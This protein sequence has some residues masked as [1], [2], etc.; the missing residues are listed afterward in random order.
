MLVCTSLLALPPLLRLS[1]AAAAL[2][3]AS[4]MCADSQT[5]C[6]ADYSVSGE[7]CCTMPNAVC[8]G[9]GQTCCP[10]GTRCIVSDVYLTRCVETSTNRIVQMGLSVCK[11]GAQLP[12]DKHRK[13]VVVLGDSVSIGYF[14]SLVPLLADVAM[15]QHSPY[16][17]S[18]GGA[19]ETAYGLQ[20]WDFFIRDPQ[21]A[22][23]QPDV[24]L[25]N[26]GLHNGAMSNATVPGQ[27]GNDAVYLS[28]LEQ[29]VQRLKVAY[30]R[31]S[32]QLLFA[33]TS[34]MLC[35]AAADD[36]I[37]RRNAVVAHM[38]ERYGIPVLDPHAPIVDRCGSPPQASCL[39]IPDCW[40][41]HCPGA[42][43]EWLAQSVIEPA[44]RRM[45]SAGLN[46]A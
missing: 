30:A 15:V 22:L 10:E 43:Y 11:P 29:I 41:P 18:D 38:M 3:G 24:L 45:L 6:P 12:M 19:E 26:W 37:V 23:L 31:T 5:L 14:A 32:T 8:C 2:D 16:D 21:G 46:Y 36:Y 34:P 17:N 1:A 28:E 39:N 40:C 7:G 33:L 27:N 13:N 35:N 4:I 44:L 9:N 42:G 20:C 25:F